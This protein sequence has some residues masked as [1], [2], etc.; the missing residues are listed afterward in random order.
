MMTY[1]SLITELR[2]LTE[3]YELEGGEEVTCDDCI[4]FEL[5]ELLKAIGTSPDQFILITQR[6][7]AR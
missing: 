2:F 6:W 1:E 5:V 4:V 7:R 3:K